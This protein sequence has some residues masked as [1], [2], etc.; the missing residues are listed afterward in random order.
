[1]DDFRG[2]VALVSGGSRGIGRACALELA[3]RGAA[4]AIAFSSN[5]GAAREVVAQVE[6]QGGRAITLMI[7]VSD[8]DA[9][10]Q[11]VETVVTQLGRLDILVNNAG[12]AIDAL[13]MRCS[14]AD[15]QRQ[16]AVNLGGAFHLVKAACRPMMRQRSGSIVNVSSVVGETGN[17]GQSAY[18]AAKAALLGFT[19]S[20]ARELASRNIRVNAV[21]PGFVDTDM[22]ARLQGDQREKLIGSIPLGRLGRPEEVAQVVAFLASEAASYVTGAV[23]RVNGGMLM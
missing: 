9:C 14:E 1:M 19:K 17:A 22:T 7:D 2:K 3:R 21:S 13:V 8:A 15:F 16:L 23:V 18:A 10:S 12:V 5:E 11:G 6:A 4:V 20:T